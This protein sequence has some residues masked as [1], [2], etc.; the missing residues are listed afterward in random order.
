MEIVDQTGLS[1]EQVT[2]LETFLNEQVIVTAKLL[3]TSVL[4]NNPVPVP[5]V[6][7]LVSTLQSVYPP[8]YAGTI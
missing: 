2:E 3:L 8:H 7:F 4:S 5:E 1:P 6:L